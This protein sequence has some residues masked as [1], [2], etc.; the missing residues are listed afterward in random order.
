MS[1]TDPIA[2]LLTRIRNAHLAKH[3]RLDVPTSKLKLEICRILKEEGLIRN[4]RLVDARPVARPVSPRPLQ[5]RSVETGPGNGRVA[6]TLR[7]FLRYSE[8]GS[9]AI[10]HLQR[11]SRPGRRVYRMASDIRPVL[12]GV[13]VGIVST[14]QGLLTDRQAR[15]RRL[16][17]E[18]LCEIW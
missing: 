15:E 18:V 12:N 7:I 6:S 3:D 8:E 9:P 14:S 4:F 13:G 16:G 10:T 2:D 1:M 17:G 11:V 5:M